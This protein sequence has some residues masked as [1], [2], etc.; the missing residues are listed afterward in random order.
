MG[1]EQERNTATSLCDGVCA[2]RASPALPLRAAMGAGNT[3]TPSQHTHTHTHHSIFGVPA[4]LQRWMGA[5]GQM[6]IAKQNE[7]KK[8]EEA[9]S[10]AHT[11][12]RREREKAKE[13]KKRTH[14]HRDRDIRKRRPPKIA[15]CSDAG[16]SLIAECSARTPRVAATKLGRPG[17]LRL[18]RT[19]VEATKLYGS[20]KHAEASHHS[21]QPL[22][23]VQQ[24]LS[25][26]YR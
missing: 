22:R 18:N 9:H 7:K 23:R 13:R 26:G 21:L 5:Q 4:A 25:V 14:R 10:N 3:P 11:H 6:T 8:K 19:R 16:R 12:T 2:L 24:T 1:K 15:Q 20:V 17:L